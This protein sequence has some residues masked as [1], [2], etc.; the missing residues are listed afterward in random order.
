MFTV[1]INTDNAAYSDSPEYEIASN[2]EAIVEDLNFGVR[3]GRV[4]DHNG[5]SVGTW[6]LSED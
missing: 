2:L 1:K 6:E 3:R 4:M 5:N